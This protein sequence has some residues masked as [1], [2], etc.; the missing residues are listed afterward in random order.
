MQ[1]RL[2]QFERRTWVDKTKACNMG[3]N[4]FQAVTGEKTETEQCVLMK[5]QVN[6]GASVR[7]AQ[8]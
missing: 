6:Y 2:K 1:L 7:E 5:I 3:L 4:L 8:G